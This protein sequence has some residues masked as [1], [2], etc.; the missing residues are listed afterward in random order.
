MVSFFLHIYREGT[1]SRRFC[2][3]KLLIPQSSFLSVLFLLRFCLKSILISSKFFNLLLFE[4]VCKIY[5]TH[6]PSINPID[7]IFFLHIC[8]SNKKMPFC[9]AN[10]HLFRLFFR[11]FKVGSILALESCYYYYYI[12]II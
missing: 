7:V 10:I 3:N 4:A 5:I 2:E 12:K 11:Y 9:F 6:L 8:S 1:F